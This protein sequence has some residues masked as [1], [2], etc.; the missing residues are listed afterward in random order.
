MREEGYH[1][2]HLHVLPGIDDGARNIG[3]SVE[4]MRGLAELG[5]AR[6][7]A[8]P[9]YDS[10]RHTYGPDRIEGLCEQVREAAEA[11]GVEIELRWGAEYAFGSRFHHDVTSREV[12][13]LG[14]SRYVLV[15][16]PEAFM[17]ATMADTL[18]QVGAA[19]YY[20]VLAHPERC[21]PFHDDVPRLERLASGRALIQVS[22]RSLAGTF[23]RTIKRTAWTLVTEDIADLVATDCH[24]PRELNKIV[25]PVLKQLRRRISADHRDRLMRRLPAKML[26]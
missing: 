5:F 9:H 4:I 6:L 23:G 7:V 22:F 20:P 24:S 10:E 2:L 8:T 19:G 12:V 25:R 18:F 13:T 21:E 11:A 14:G 17:P 3:A 26:A 15:E 16:L 1:D